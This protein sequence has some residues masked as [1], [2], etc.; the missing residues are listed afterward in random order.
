MQPLPYILFVVLAQ[1]IPPTDALVLNAIA[2]EYH[3][4][5]DAY[6]LLYAIRLAENGAP[7]RELGILIPAAMRHKGNHVKS[8]TLQARWCAGTIRRRYNGDLEAFATRYC[9]P[10]AANDPRGLNANWLRNVRSAW[11]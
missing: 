5:S 8:L 7:G 11:K 1:P 9:P 6:R 2:C 4:S 10:G 3:L